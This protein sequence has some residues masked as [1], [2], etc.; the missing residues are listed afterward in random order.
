LDPEAMKENWRKYF[1][2]VLFLSNFGRSIVYTKILN[3]Q[4]IALHLNLGIQYLQ[5]LNSL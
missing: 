5:Q 3:K 4:G 1:R 2:F